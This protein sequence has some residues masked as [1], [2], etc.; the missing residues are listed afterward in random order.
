[1]GGKKVQKGLEESIRRAKEK[2]ERS[3]TFEGG[4]K[5]GIFSQS[6]NRRFIA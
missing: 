6:A 3:Q 5:E 1:V 2:G 4:G